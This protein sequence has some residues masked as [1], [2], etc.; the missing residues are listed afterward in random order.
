M[1]T[2]MSAET[3]TAMT[4]AA[5]QAFD[6]DGV[7]GACVGV[8]VGDEVLEYVELKR[9]LDVMLVG[10]IALPVGIVALLV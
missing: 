1:R 7:D 9:M 2:A 5:I 6:D 10:I 4:G 8:G 3:N